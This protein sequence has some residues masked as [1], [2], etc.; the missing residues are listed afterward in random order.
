M[1]FSTPKKSFLDL[2]TELRL[3]VYSHFPD[4]RTHITTAKHTP[5]SSHRNPWPNTPSP[6]TQLSRSCKT[7]YGECRDLWLKRSNFDFVQ[8]TSWLDRIPQAAGGF[9]LLTT[10]HAQDSAK[11][12]KMAFKCTWF[13]VW[14]HIVRGNI[15]VREI[16]TN[17]EDERSP[18]DYTLE[19][20]RAIEHLRAYIIKDAISLEGVDWTKVQAGVGLMKSYMRIAAEK[21]RHS[22]WRLTDVDPD[23]LWNCDHGIARLAEHWR[24]CSFGWQGCV[25]QEAQVTM[26]ASFGRM[27]PAVASWRSIRYSARSGIH[28]S[29]QNGRVRFRSSRL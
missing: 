14:V 26:F 15:T 6:L 5:E 10:K 25:C 18:I 9:K 22:G 13:A 11:I 4:G 3:Q 16:T 20:T 23:E 19:T 27:A 28:V 17:A 7:L 12:R 2:P 24:R 29:V 8:S 21:S 1:P